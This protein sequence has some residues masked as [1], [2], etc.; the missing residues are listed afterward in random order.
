MYSSSFAARV[1]DV[2]AV[3]RAE[4]REVELAQA[5]QRVE[6]GGQGALAGGDEDAALPQHGVA[7]EAD[8]TEEQADAVGRVPGR[9]ERTKRPDLLAVDRQHNGRTE[10]LGRPPRDRH[11]SA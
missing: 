11:A 5:A 4:H 9:A 6:V 10:Q 1:P 8:R 2:G 7:R 3:A